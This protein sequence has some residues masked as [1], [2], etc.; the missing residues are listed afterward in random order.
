MESWP[1]F[2]G[3]LFQEMKMMQLEIIFLFLP[4]EVYE[5]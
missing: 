3:Q 4:G 5:R 2:F 1:K